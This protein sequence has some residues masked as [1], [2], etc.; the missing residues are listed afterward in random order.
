MSTFSTNEQCSVFHG[1]SEDVGSLLVLFTGCVAF[2]KELY[3]DFKN[4]R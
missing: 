2:W 4:M 1:L 3:S